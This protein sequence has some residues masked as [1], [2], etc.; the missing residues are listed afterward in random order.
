LGLESERHLPAAA[1]N[2]HFALQF[3]FQTNTEAVAGLVILGQQ[4]GLCLRT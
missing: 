1:R 4:V 2:S 3:H